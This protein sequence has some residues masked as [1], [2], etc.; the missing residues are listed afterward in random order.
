MRCVV[1][2]QQSASSRKYYEKFKHKE[3]HK[4]IGEK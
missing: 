4:M 2:D 1:Y 3:S